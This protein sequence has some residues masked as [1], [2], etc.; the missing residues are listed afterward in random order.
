MLLA[1]IKEGFS[2]RR[3]GSVVFSYSTKVTA[4]SNGSKLQQIKVFTADEKGGKIRELLT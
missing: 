2:F 4:K 1:G 3:R